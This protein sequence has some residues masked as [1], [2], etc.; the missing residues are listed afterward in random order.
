MVVRV[1]AVRTV[2]GKTLQQI[3][4]LFKERARALRVAVGERIASD[5]VDSSPVDTGTYIL[6]HRA[7]GTDGGDAAA[8]RSSVDPVRK[9]RGRNPAQFKGLAKGN[10]KRSVSAAAMQNATDIWFQNSSM[11]AQRVESLGWP[12][13]LFGNPRI[14]GPGPYRVY[15]KARAAVPQHIRDAARGLGF[16]AK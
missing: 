9:Q 5:I 4:L 8:D 6:A 15:A 11:H 3:E 10:L 16:T 14:S 13:P 12:A 1:T 7:S 2:T